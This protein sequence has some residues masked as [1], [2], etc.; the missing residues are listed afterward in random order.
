MTPATKL[1]E[2][3]SPAQISERGGKPILSPNKSEEISAIARYA[4]QH[5]LAIEITA[6]SVC[7][8]C[9]LLWMDDLRTN[10]FRFSMLQIHPS[11]N[12]LN[13]NQLRT[14]SQGSVSPFH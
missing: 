7:C 2:L 1:D 3:L 9:K 4:N 5:N 10:A 11:S 8:P 14:R 6:G 13:P 12:Y